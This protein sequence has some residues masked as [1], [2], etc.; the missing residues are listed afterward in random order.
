MKKIRYAFVAVAS[1]MMLYACSK[2]TTLE[3]EIDLT[4]S[5]LVI[6]ASELE[7]Q[8]LDLVNE[9]RSS[10]GASTLVSSSSSYKYAQEHNTYMISK[11]KLSHDNFDARASSIAS[12]IDAIEV[13]E[14]VARFYSSAELVVDSWLKSSSHKSTLEKPFTHT[15]LSVQLD[16]EGRPYFTQIF[17]KVS[18][19]NQ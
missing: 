19:N 14:N 11:N 3:E 7:Q 16:K 8:V 6:D 1:L 10:I 13:A 4:G 9:H 12:E 18:S 2:S 17:M 5:K 15:T